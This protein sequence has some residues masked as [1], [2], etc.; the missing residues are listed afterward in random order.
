MLTSD[1]CSCNSDASQTAQ[2]ASGG[3]LLSPILALVNFLLLV[4]V[5]FLGKK[6]MSKD[7]TIQKLRD[8]IKKAQEP[9]KKPK[10]RIYPEPGD[11]Q[12]QDS[13]S[14]QYFDP[15]VADQVQVTRGKSD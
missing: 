15:D 1:L 7:K 6:M 3:G 10:R 4:L 5:Y 13:A 8:E 2:E 12:P 11:E 14:F 9:P